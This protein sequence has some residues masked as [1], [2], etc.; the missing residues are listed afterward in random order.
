MAE[1]ARYPDTIEMAAA[2]LTEAGRYP[3]GPE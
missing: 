1:A 3:G 2:I